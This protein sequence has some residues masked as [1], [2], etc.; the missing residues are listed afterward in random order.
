MNN[1]EHYK[2]EIFDIY[3]GEEFNEI[4]RTKGYSNS[5]AFIEASMRVMCKYN[6]IKA[7]HYDVA[8][9]WLAEEYKPTFLVTKVEY[10]I[11]DWINIYKGDSNILLRDNYMYRDLKKLGMFKSIKDDK[12]PLKDITKRIYTLNKGE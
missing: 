8:I 3:D 10:T 2:K 6:N 1:L 9:N 5:S 7:P 4:R 11:L 12:I